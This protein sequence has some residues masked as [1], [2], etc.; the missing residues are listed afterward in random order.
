MAPLHPPPFVYMR[1]LA[2]GRCLTIDVYPDG[3]AGLAVGT[4]D[5][6]DDLWLYPDVAAALAAARPWDGTGEP[7]GWRAHPLTGRTA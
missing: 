3:T 2:E 5:L 7:A 6:I 4:P 1:T